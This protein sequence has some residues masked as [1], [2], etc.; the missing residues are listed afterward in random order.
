MDNRDE[1]SESSEAHIKSMIEEIK[2]SKDFSYISKAIDDHYKSY[3]IEYMYNYLDY[4]SNKYKIRRKIT[5]EMKRKISI[6]EI[7]E[8]LNRLAG[9]DIK[10]KENKYSVMDILRHEYDREIPDFLDLYTN[11]TDPSKIEKEKKNAVIT[12][13]E[14]VENS[15][16]ELSEMDRF[17]IETY[18]GIKNDPLYK[19]YL[20]THLSYFSEKLTYLSNITMLTKGEKPKDYIR[21][22]AMKKAKE[23]KEAKEA[24]AQLVNVDNSNLVEQ[25]ESKTVLRPKFYHGAGKRKKS[26]AFV[27][28]VPGTGVITVNGKPFHRYFNNPT[29]RGKALMPL[30]LTNNSS[31]WDITIKVF[32]G[33]VNGQCF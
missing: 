24:N 3:K 19:H 28:M 9:V 32:G 30:D 16:I 7:N 11:S 1:D 13:I 26:R 8:L 14:K 5:E 6:P 4:F 31:M 15:P 2:N 12:E 20:R 33:G 21:W 17:E 29:H 25:K 18:K 22:E 10:K 23:D 27:K